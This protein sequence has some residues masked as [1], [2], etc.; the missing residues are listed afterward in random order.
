[1]DRPTF[2]VW[3]SLNCFLMI[4]V[5]WSITSLAR[6][7][8]IPFPLSL[9]HGIGTELGIMS[10]L[11]II[12][13]VAYGHRYTV[14]LI[15]GIVGLAGLM[16]GMAFLLYLTPLHE[17]FPSL[18]TGPY[19]GQVRYASWLMSRAMLMLGFQSIVLLGIGLGLAAF[20]VTETYARLRAIGSLV[21]AWL[22]LAGG[23]F[24]FVW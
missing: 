18:V 1:M 16:G 19:G 3:V 11:T 21:M 13:F 10:T 22:T 6:Q 15:T 7:A 12:G 20:Y 23:V 14:P 2:A 4:A 8:G 9:L 17:V 5:G 24:I